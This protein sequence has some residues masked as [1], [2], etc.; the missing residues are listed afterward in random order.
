MRQSALYW[1]GEASGEM[2]SLV[3][4]HLCLSFIKMG[5]LNF[6]LPTSNPLLFVPELRAGT[7]QETDK[8]TDML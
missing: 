8:Q 5:T 7:R 6:D 2:R 1:Q 4:M 3:M